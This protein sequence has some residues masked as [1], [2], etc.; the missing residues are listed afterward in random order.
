MRFCF[1]THSNDPLYT[2]YIYISI[3]ISILFISTCVYQYF[4]FAV[5]LSEVVTGIGTRG[6]GAFMATFV[7]KIFCCEFCFCSVQNKSKIFYIN[8]LH[9]VVSFIET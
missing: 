5:S 8:L 6:S 9:N 4:S 7:T 3:C 2:C 1:Y